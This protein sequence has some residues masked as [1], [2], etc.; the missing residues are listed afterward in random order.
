MKSSLSHSFGWCVRALRKERGLTQVE[1]SER[2]GF[3][4]TYLSRIENGQVNP[5][6]N[7]MEVIANGLGLSIFEL[8][9]QVRLRVNDQIREPVK[10]K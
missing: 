10:A 7:A 3:F 5:T 2:C 1:F 9:D 6:L 4:Q 8:I